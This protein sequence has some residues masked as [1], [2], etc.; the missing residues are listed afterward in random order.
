MVRD[1]LGELIL[2]VPGTLFVPYT[3]TQGEVG[4]TVGLQAEVSAEPGWSSRVAIFE[5]T[6]RDGRPDGPALTQLNL[7]PGEQHRVLLAIGADTAP[8]SPV[9]IR[10]IATCGVR[11]TTTDPVLVRVQPA[12][13]TLPLEHV[14]G[15]A[16]ATIGDIVP[17]TVT[18][19][20]PLDVPL[21]IQVD[22]TLPDFARYVPRAD[23][24]APAVQG[25]T[26]RW[27]V[28]VPAGGRQSLTYR[29]AVTAAPSS[30][31]TSVA[32]ARAEYEGAVL[33]SPAVQASVKLQAGV[34]DSR[35]T[36]IGRVF[37]DQNGNGQYD[38]PDLPTAG[39]RVVLSNG[40][41]TLTDPQGN[42]TFRQLAPGP[43]LVALDPAT[44]PSKPA[45][46]NL[47]RS[48]DVQ[49]LARVDFA[50]QPTTRSAAPP[51]S[52]PA[53]GLQTASSQDFI[54]FPLPN[55]V[56]RGSSQTRV[57]LEGPSGVPARL[58]VNGREV[59]ASLLGE[60]GPGET[61]G[62]VRL[63]YIGVPLQSG[64][65]LLE[66]QFGDRQEQL[67]ITLAGTPQRLVFRPISVVA[68]GHTPLEVEIAALDAQ[69]QAS[70]QGFVTVQ[71]DLEPTLPDAAPLESGY[72]LALRDGV[73]RLV[74][75]PLP[76]GREWTLKAALGNLTAETR[77]Y[78][79]TGGQTLALGQGSV[80][81]TFGQDGLAVHGLARGYL[82]APL[83]GGHV[84]A[85]LDT[86]GFPAEE[87]F[88][89]FPV[90]G[91]STEAQL[92][93]RSEDGFAVRYD[94]ADLSAGYSTAPLGLPGLENL[95]VGT[96]LQVERR[97]PLQIR[98]FAG[99][100]A[101]TTQAEVFQAN[102]SFYRLQFAPR[103]GSERVVVQSAGSERV[104]VPGQDYVLDASGLLIL[105]AP[106]SPY[107]THFLPVRLS[108]TYSPATAQRT[109]LA[110]GVGAQYRTGPWTL[111]FSVAQLQEL[112][113]G[114]GLTYTTPELQ[115]RLNYR[116][117][118]L[119]PQG[120]LTVEARGQRGPWS[121]Q[122]SISSAPDEGTLG[123]ASAVYRFGVRQ[124][125]L[126]QRF[127]PNVVRTEAAL[128]QRFGAFSL[129]LG[130]DYDWT[131]G[132]V[133]VLALG[134]YA[135]GPLQAELS[136]AQPLTSGVRAPETRLVASYQ[137][138]STL[139]AQ[140]QLQQQWGVGLS[141]E[142][143]LQQ[144]LGSSN[145][146]VSYQ[147]P[148]A[149]GEASRARIGVEVP[150]PIN[151]QWSATFGAALEREMGSGTFGANLSGGVRYQTSALVA[152]LR[153]DYTLAAGTQQLTVRGGATGS[154][155]EGQT[156]AADA[157]VQLLPTVES[158]FGVSYAL[159]RGTFSLLTTHRLQRG[160]TSALEGLVQANVQTSPT[161]ELQ[162]SL[163]YRIPFTDAVP[164]VQLGLSATTLLTKSFGLSARGYL[165]WQPTL[166]T[167]TA[168]AGLDG[169][170]RLAEPVWVVAGY[171]WSNVTGLTP[172]ARP[173]FHIRL[174]FAGGTP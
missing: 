131:S 3:I 59:P 7:N 103:L 6:N 61:P 122:A 46:G 94:R 75:A 82:E 73:A 56:V 126:R 48:T 84:R 144:R 106:L 173:G 157:S 162:P 95:P 113:Y 27:T 104:L 88:R 85:A 66:A 100:I 160:T 78:A 92:P 12:L 111:Q 174:D 68:D 40:L 123:N 18:L 138:S 90:T 165:L 43:W 108:V 105:A 28:D 145:F 70:G 39:V 127:E 130:F 149:S 45:D 63:T 172:E 19:R 53:A 17:F 141:G 170:Y 135:T 168:A 163:A 114:L 21:K 134:R 148:G 166:N 55:T 37:V 1:E 31:L 8:Q 101:T 15:L 109:L 25:H 150:L 80:G 136:H 125:L 107:D 50:L 171:T 169:R 81:V 99:R 35:G 142:V 44:L 42:Y 77:L 76:V 51:P 158:S 74:L 79:T 62:S 112:Y 115:G 32:Q 87:D 96:A 23:D 65:N 161:F 97:G 86:Q 16:Q 9:Q 132:S 102:G 128:E 83:A 2:N 119:N 124:A 58:R 69:G 14:A 129:G 26:L 147:L 117:D 57:V 67:P 143:G 156:L 139:S 52:T 140:A 151:S 146:K 164:S 36:L 89:L 34:F 93:L 133:G 98:A 91:S 116:K 118:P 110:A 47:R 24:G 155:G 60:Q 137:L 11:Q 167:W 71:T 5:D 152:T 49:G 72:Q 153:S 38:A 22:V 30:Q 10:L 154:L 4:G 29:V 121:V 13:V 33:S 64:Q 20:N 120:R 41:Q 159:R 54:R